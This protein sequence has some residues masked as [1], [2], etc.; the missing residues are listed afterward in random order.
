MA[1]YIYSNPDLSKTSNRF[2]G[3]SIDFKGIN[4]PNSTYWSLCNWGMDLTEFK[5]TYPDAKG[6]GAYGGLQTLINSKTAILSF[7][8]VLYTENGET[9]SHRA[10]REYPKGAEREFGGEGEGTNYIHEF[11]WPTNVWIRFFIRSWVDKIGDAHVGEWIQNLSTNEWT[12]FAYFNTKLKNSYIIGG[13]SQF[14]ENFNAKYFGYERSFQIK[15]MYALDKKYRKWISLNSSTLYYDPPSYGYNTAGTHEIGYTSSYFYGSSGLPVDDQK[16]YD[17]NNPARIKGTIN[18][19]D[20]PIF[21]KPAFKSLTAVITTTSLTV[22]WTLDSKTSPCYKY[23]I[24][25]LYYTNYEY[26]SK[27]TI[28]TYKPEARNVTF[29][30]NFKGKYQIKATCYGIS[31][32]IVTKSIY[33]E[34]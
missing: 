25:A 1:K 23:Q 27:Y 34:I 20:T 18:Q 15:N 19:P 30:Y 4:T 31:N 14:Q 3:F 10:S 17:E 21:T 33:K 29:N 11:N 16:S 6:G 13:L 2:E 22:Y 28:I 8:E 5:K 9:K 24:Q 12:L 26:E 7:W 32:D